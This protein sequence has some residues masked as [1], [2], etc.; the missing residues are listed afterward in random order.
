MRMA[1]SEA[2]TF[3]IRRAEIDDADA[4]A[5]VHVAS[6][7]TSYRGVLPDAT[8][9]GLDVGA[10]AERWRKNL[11]EAAS[12]TFVACAGDGRLLGFASV[13]P[14][15]AGGAI[16]GE[17]YAIYLLAEAKRAGAGRALFA[18]ATAWLR[19]QGWTSML[20]WVLE[21]NPPA[22]AFYEAMGG[23]LDGRKDTVIDGRPFATVAYVWR[24]L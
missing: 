12:V 13:G 19:A 23:V 20:V 7:Q 14:H 4:I 17:L 21:N 6:W 22:R 24:A 2:V 11:A 15:R 3:T 18:A 9:D 10:R 1:R 8:L 16:T 5:R